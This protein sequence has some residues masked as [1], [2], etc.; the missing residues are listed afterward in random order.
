[1]VMWLADRICDGEPGFNSWLNTFLYRTIPA[2]R[3]LYIVSLI[4]RRKN[5]PAGPLEA[6]PKW[7]LV[8]RIVA[9]PGFANSPRLSAFFQ[10]VSKHSLRG[11]SASLSERSIGEAVFERPPGYDPRDDNIVR[12][13]A[14]RLR[15]RL[16]DYFE[17]EGAA[18]PL[19]VT[20]PRGSY[21]PLFEPA[22]SALVL[23]PPQSF[24]APRPPPESAAPE[25]AA[26]LLSSWASRRT[27]FSVAAIALLAA[28]IVAPS[29]L[30]YR[31][32]FPA[33]SATPS[34]KLWS[35]LFRADQQTII[36]PADSSL[37]IAR[38]LVGHPIRLQDYA[39]GMYRQVIDCTKP[40][41]L[42]MVK[43][44]EEFRYTSM[45]DLEFAAKVSH[46]PEAIPS[47]TEIRFARDLELKDLKES[48]LIL[49]GSQEA[50]PWL[51][52]ILPEMNFVVQD[53]PAAGPL[54]VENRNPKPGER[55]EYLYDPHDAQGHGLATIAFLPNLKD[56]GSL[57][58]VQGFSFAGT[59]AAAEFV[60]N[61][62]DLDA[63]FPAYAGNRSKLPH[64]EILLAT[65]EVNG[66]ASRPTPLAV[67]IEPVKRD[68]N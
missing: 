33:W 52:A 18:E 58:V 47:R 57:L 24:D 37:V 31:N 16:Q 1:M 34:H 2:A 46:L 39:G 50:D 25:S 11:D 68:G 36:V 62:R 67:H 15:L 17:E 63:L 49:A 54:R 30:L 38:L 60:T 43:T 9:S 20:I 27:V 35:Q 10:Y 61:G 41:D 40:C 59:Q 19:R 8:Q 22:A 48:N 12:S 21:V 65:T 7:L 53:D 14:S 45:S 55:S 26:P 23:D 56:T 6:N 51:S 4:D 3:I 64:F 32:Y 66:M 13:H 5:S 44:V 28:G 29:I 42:S